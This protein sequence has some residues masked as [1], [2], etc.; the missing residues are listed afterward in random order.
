MSNQLVEL[1]STISKNIIRKEI[2]NSPKCW[3]AIVDSAS[4]T[5]GNMCN[6]YLNGDTTQPIVGVVNKTNETLVTSDKVYLFS[7]TGSLN[8]CIILFKS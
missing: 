2:R 1:I 5:H 6:V 4:T 3:V 8:S 7:P